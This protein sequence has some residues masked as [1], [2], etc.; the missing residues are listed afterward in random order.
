MNWRQYQNELIVLSTFVI[1]FSTYLYRNGKMND[2]VNGGQ[3]TQKSLLAMK[4][5]VT[6]KKIWADKKIGTKVQRLKST[7]SSS[8]VKWR[9]GTKKVTANYTGLSGSELNKLTTDILNM[10]VQIVLFQT[11][12]IGSTYKVE[13][14]CKW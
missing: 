11:E 1:M 7:V 3:T 8:K 6:L 13:F 10:P 14:K 5:V 9:K 12:K 2:Q 4:E